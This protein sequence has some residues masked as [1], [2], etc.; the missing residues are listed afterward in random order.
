MKLKFIYFRY[1]LA[2]RCTEFFCVCLLEVE[3]TPGFIRNPSVSMNP[4]V[5]CFLQ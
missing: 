3:L 2:I 5:I 1:T 4:F